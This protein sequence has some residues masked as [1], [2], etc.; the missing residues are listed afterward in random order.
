MFAKRLYW[1]LDEDV[2]VYDDGDDIGG[3]G[4]RGDFGSI[5]PSKLL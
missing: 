4:A 5:S 1:V 2:F 3:G